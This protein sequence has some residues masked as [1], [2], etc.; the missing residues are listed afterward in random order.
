MAK[1]DWEEM[2]F[3]YPT[4]S[5]RLRRDVIEWLQQHGDKKFLRK[6]IYKLY[7]RVEAKVL[8]DAKRKRHKRQFK[9]LKKGQSSEQTR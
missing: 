3:R 1:P 9:E 2:E 7:A 4:Y 6:L 5:L 8:I